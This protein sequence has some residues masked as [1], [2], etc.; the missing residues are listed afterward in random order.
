MVIAELGAAPPHQG[1]PYVWARLAFGRLA[2]SLVALAWWLEAPVWLG[3]SLARA[4]TA[5]VGSA[6]W[7]GLGWTQEPATGRGLFVE[8]HGGERQQVDNDIKA[9]LDAMI[10]SRPLAYG[11]I[12]S[13]I[14]GIE[15]RAMPVCAVAVAIYRSEPWD[16]P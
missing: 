9:T 1:G 13:E 11:D 15:C 2:G 7:A 3:G 5:A 12:R 4:E 6:A 8:L 10:A 14:V 16:R